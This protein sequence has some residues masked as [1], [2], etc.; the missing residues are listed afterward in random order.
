MQVFF[1]SLSMLVTLSVISRAEKGKKLIEVKRT[2]SFVLFWF[3]GAR[4]EL[5]RKETR[6]VSA[7][8]DSIP[9]GCLPGRALQL[10]IEHNS[11]PCQPQVDGHL[12]N[13]VV[14]GHTPPPPPPLLS[15]LCT[16]ILSTVLGFLWFWG[17]FV[18]CIMCYI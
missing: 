1:L 6:S 10:P 7:L 18:V 9:T 14:A 4:K 5:G 3:F 8:S 2:S 16:P 17:S 12:I 11:I 13:G 15:A